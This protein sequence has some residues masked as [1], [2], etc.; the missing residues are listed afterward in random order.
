MGWKEVLAPDFHHSLEIKKG[1]LWAFKTWISVLAVLLISYVALE[2]LFYLWRCGFPIC[3]RDNTPYIVLYEGQ[4]P[5]CMQSPLCPECRVHSV[6]TNLFSSLLFLPL[7]FPDSKCNK[8][9]WSGSAKWQF[10]SVLCQGPFR[11]QNIPIPLLISVFLPSDVY[12]C[13]SL[14]THCCHSACRQTPTDSVTTADC[15][16]LSQHL[17]SED[18]SQTP[19]EPPFLAN[20]L[21]RNWL[22]YLQRDLSPR[23]PSRT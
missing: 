6:Q 3:S 13:V 12:L 2:R 21:L 1:W 19:K 20:F 23:F 18:A 7:P 11:F 22:L 15:T 16:G 14:I 8:Q 17:I 5:W 9:K 10:Q 4:I